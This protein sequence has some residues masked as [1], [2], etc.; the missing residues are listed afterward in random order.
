[1]RRRRFST[2]LSR[3]VRLSDRRDSIDRKLVEMDDIVMVEAARHL[4]DNSPHYKEC[5][6]LIKRLW[7]RHGGAIARILREGDERDRRCAVRAI[8]LIRHRHPGLLQALQDDSAEVRHEAI[9]ALRFVR[10][11]TAVEPLTA[12]TA[13]LNP[14]VRLEAIRA[15]GHQRRIEATPTLM[16]L[17]DSDDSSTRCEAARALGMIGDE[18]ALPALRERLQSPDRKLRDAVKSALAS[19]DC[20]RRDRTA[21]R[22]ADAR[23]P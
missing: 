20:R 16:P 11:R 23:L 19:Y 3:L 5:S 13:G 15:L 8:G 21:S 7:G 6:R 14:K 9:R 2:L 4:I 12:L 17:L 10:D 1:M 18:T 22:P